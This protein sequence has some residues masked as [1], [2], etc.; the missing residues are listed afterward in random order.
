MAFGA[1]EMVATATGTNY[2]QQWTGISDTAY[3]WTYLGL[4]LASSIGQIA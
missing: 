1:N 2:I 4:N 3:S